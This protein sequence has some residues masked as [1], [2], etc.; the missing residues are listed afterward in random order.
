MDK[1]MIINL[2]LLIF[3]EQLFIKIDLIFEGE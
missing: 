1:N 2:G 3:V